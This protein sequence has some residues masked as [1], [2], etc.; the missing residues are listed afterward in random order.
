MYILSYQLLIQ[1]AVIIDFTQFALNFPGN[2]HRYYQPFPAAGLMYND[3]VYT[4]LNKK[5]RMGFLTQ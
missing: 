4:D 3:N 5:L 1:E 2:I